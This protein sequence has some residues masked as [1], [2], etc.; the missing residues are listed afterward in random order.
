[1]F[2]GCIPALLLKNG[3]YGGC[4]VSSL[5]FVFEAPFPATVTCFLC[6]SVPAASKH[7]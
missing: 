5:V 2:C 6:T 1:M 4:I 7:F 3:A